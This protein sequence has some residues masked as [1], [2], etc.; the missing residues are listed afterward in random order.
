MRSLLLMLMAGCG[1]RSGEVMDEQVGLRPSP[2]ILLV[3]IDDAGIDAFDMYPDLG[4][5]R[6]S[7]PTL[8]ALAENGIVFDQAWSSP[9]CSPTRASLLTGRYP[10]RHGQGQAVADE[11]NVLADETTVLTRV[12]TRG[13][14]GLTTGL[15][16][17]WHLGTD[18]DGP[19][20]VGFGEFRG[21]MNGEVDD[22]FS[23][24]KII[25]GEAVQV[26]NYATTEVVNDASDWIN[27]RNGPW[28]AMV[29]FNAAHTPFH[30][31]PDELHSLE[32]LT[33]TES[34]ININTDEYFRAMLEAFDTELGRLIGEISP[35]VLEET[36]I[37]FT[38]DNGSMGATMQGLLPNTMAKST[39]HEGGVHV[40]L[41]ISG[42]LVEAP[43]R[44]V[45]SMVSTMDLH[46]T[47]LDIAGVPAV[48]LGD[49]DYD[50]VSLLPL[51]QDPDAG[52]V[53]DLLLN[54]LFG[55]RVKDEY[56]GRAVR[57]QRYK[58]IDIELGSQH[59]YDL[60]VDP[61]ESEDLLLAGT[62]DADAKASYDELSEY[63]ASLPPLP[64]DE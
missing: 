58:L 26:E 17:K 14:S 51:V 25:N 5:E 28:L 40:P 56:Q 22:F 15:F 32:G 47:I 10:F 54:E 52:P 7:T 34:D 53:R 24:E 12:L 55:T 62:M 13:A 37:I 35:A 3:I 50:A 38:A 63:L 27:S 18:V 59:L 48:A 46:A 31:P 61:L 41:L 60:E 11:E 30:L 23:Y 21:T 2:N 39:L 33:G 29:S 44:R 1:S 4:I 16:G 8:D 57:D 6:A 9:L 45:S 36:I 49:A 64:P 42:A 19:N 43:G 20:E